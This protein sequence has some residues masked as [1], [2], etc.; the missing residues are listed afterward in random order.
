MKSDLR[1]II[2]LLLLLV[3][4]C[5]LGMSF[6]ESI[7]CAGELPGGHDAA[8][9]L[10][11]ADPQQHADAE[12]PCAPSDGHDDHFC[13]GDCGCP[14]Q[15]PLP[16]APITLSSVYALPYRYHGEPSRFIPEVYRSLFVPPDSA[17]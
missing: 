2:A 3:T 13:G 10:H 8:P 4:I 17:A 12:C 16:S 5:G 6:S 9:A 14:C 11:G 15:A 1:R 7:V